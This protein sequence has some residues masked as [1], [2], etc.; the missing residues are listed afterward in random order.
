MDAPVNPIIDS[1]TRDLLIPAAGTGIVYLILSGEMI[2]VRLAIGALLASMMC[3]YFGT[4]ATA[5]ILKLGT[6]W[7]PI[8]GAGFGFV[9]HMALLGVIK[10]G[11][12]WRADPAAFIARFVP[13]I[14]KD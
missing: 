12:S 7:Y 13:F 9:G 10:L 8:L 11:Q 4:L 14:R 5:H 6:D 2:T 3:G 1:T